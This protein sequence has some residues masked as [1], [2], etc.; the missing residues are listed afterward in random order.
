MK[1][2]LF[3]LAGLLSMT[4][5]S[6]E[7]NDLLLSEKKL[8]EKIQKTWKVLYANSNDSREKWTFSNGEV[9]LNYDKDYPSLDTTI[10]YTFI[11]NY[12]ID[13]RFSKAYVKLSG[14][15]FPD[16]L[17]F[18]N[19]AFT[20]EDLNR[21]WTI[22]MLDGDVLYLSATDNRGAIRSLEFVKD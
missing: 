21:V 9:L 22:V 15:S 2:I 5:I 10:N 11:G 14:F 4:F 18:T 13:A 8:N 17:Q 12:S 3:I 19:S 16:S 7:Q 6:C 1:N 20:D